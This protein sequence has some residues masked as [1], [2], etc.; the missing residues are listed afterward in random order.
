MKPSNQS[1]QQKETSFVF[2]VVE[3]VK[4]AYDSLKSFITR[5]MKK[6]SL[7]GAVVVAVAIAKAAGVNLGFLMAVAALK[8]QAVMNYLSSLGTNAVALIVKAKAFAID[9][10]DGIFSLVK[11][12]GHVLLSKAIQVKD[13]IVS[14]VRQ[15]IDW[16]TGAIALDEHE[17]AQAA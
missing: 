2:R 10:A 15:F 7:A 3:V 17:Y 13:L 1:N 16:V 8:G 11:T 4:S 12:L 14:K 5:N 6:V 9:N